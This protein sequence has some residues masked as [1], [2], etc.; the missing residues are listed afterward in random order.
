[1]NRDAKT[2][3]QG[4]AAGFAA[5][6]PPPQIAI[7]P[8]NRCIYNCKHCDRKVV[9][10]EGD[11]PILT[12]SRALTDIR[13][14]FGTREINIAGGEPLLYGGLLDLVAQCTEEGHWVNL[15]TNGALL[16]P[17]LAR[18]LGRW[19]LKQ[20]VLSLDGFQTEHDALRQAGAFEAAERSVEVLHENAPGVS[21]GVICVINRLNVRSLL[22]FTEYVMNMRSIRAMSFQA[23]VSHRSHERE[24]GWVEKHPLWPDDL[25]ELDSVLDEL[26]AWSNDEV[27]IATSAGQFRLMK[28][29]FREPTRFVLRECLSWKK[30]M[31][32]EANGDVKYCLG[33]GAIGNLN[34]QT[35][36]EIW[37]S[38]E[39]GRVGERIA[40]CRTVCHYVVN[41]GFLTESLPEAVR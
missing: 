40:R 16:T 9:P 23:L 12:I 31:V 26:A 4:R 30:M 3:A 37:D 7:N 29:Y 36:D 10:G 24:E 19:G 18:D 38:P 20:Y 21:L 22:D 39:H 17:A 35:F 34:R 11:L 1:M 2:P 8:T 28:A 5:E 41:C 33:V 25:E 15:V 6:A 14:R 27:Q 13:R 32:I